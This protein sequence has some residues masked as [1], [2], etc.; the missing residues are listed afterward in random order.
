MLGDRAPLMSSMVV[1]EAI[2]DLGCWSIKALSEPPKNK[3]TTQ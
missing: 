3:E 1:A 2:D